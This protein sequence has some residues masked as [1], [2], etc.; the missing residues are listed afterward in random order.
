MANAINVVY[1]TVFAHIPPQILQ[2]AMYVANKHFKLCNNTQEFI[3]QKIIR[4]R[5]LD[6]LNLTGGKFKKL[7]IKQEYMERMSHDLAG[8]AGGDGGF[9]LYRIPP[10][11][12]DGLP[13]IHCLS[14]QYPYA[15]SNVNGVSGL[16]VNN[17]GYDL[18]SQTDQVLNSYTLGRP[19]NHP[20]GQVLSGD[21]IKLYPSQYSFTGYV[22]TVRLALDETFEQVQPSAVESLSKLVMLATRAWCYTNMIIDIDR[23]AMECGADIGKVK[24]II[25]EW[26]D[27]NQ[28]Y[29]E[30]KP[31][32]FAAQQLDSD[33]R[34]RLYQYSL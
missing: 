29:E 27:A 33:M 24:E 34:Q 3:L 4:E 26:R 5:V 31:L 7:V 16:G 22:V 9:D 19:L 1:N 8:W 2:M 10:E 23:A 28:T 32:W 6:E 14:V 25:E 21:L 11:A 17:S 30:T 18:L 20:T 12:R 15:S 13:M